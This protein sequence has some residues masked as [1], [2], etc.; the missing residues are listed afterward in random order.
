M[1]AYLATEGCPIAGKTFFVYGGT[2][3][4]F[5]PW[6]IVDTIQVDHTWSLDELA[7]QA[8]KWGEVEFDQSIS[9]D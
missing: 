1:V 8:A 6:T 4:L 9:I 5:Q 3:Q 2:V 7:E